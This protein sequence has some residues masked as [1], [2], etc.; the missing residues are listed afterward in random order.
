MV[1]PTWAVHASF[2]VR[3]AATGGSSAG[4][5]LSGL[6]EQADSPRA[7]A[8]TRAINAREPWRVDRFKWDSDFKGRP[9]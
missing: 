1:G 4:L 3:S 6:D 7:D 9:P 2:A 8:T 5:G